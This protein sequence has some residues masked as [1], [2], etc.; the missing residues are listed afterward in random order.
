M[1]SDTSK[2]DT[3]NFIW[4]QWV[5]SLAQQIPDLHDAFDD[6]DIKLHALS[7]QR[8]VQ[9]PMRLFVTYVGEHL[10]L[11]CSRD[12]KLFQELYISSGG[13]CLPADFIEHYRKMTPE[14]R[15]YVWGTLES[16]TTLAGSMNAEFDTILRETKEK[17][18]LSA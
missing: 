3:F 17:L 11:L 10:P 6:I 7:A 13:Q 14:A 18:A 12:E 5:L 2:C 15:G 4:S 8:G 1:S 16:L 9:E